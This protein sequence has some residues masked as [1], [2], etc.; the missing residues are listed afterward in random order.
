LVFV[1]RFSPKWRLRARLEVRLNQSAVTNNCQE[2]SSEGVGFSLLRTLPGLDQAAQTRFDCSRFGRQRIKKTLKLK[3]LSF[4]WAVNIY[5]TEQWQSIISLKLIT[6]DYVNM[7]GR[8]YW[9]NQPINKV[10]SAHNLLQGTRL[11]ELKFYY[12]PLFASLTLFNCLKQVSFASSIF[13]SIGLYI[14]SG[15]KYGAPIAAFSV[16]KRFGD[17]DFQSVIKTSILSRSNL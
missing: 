16:I 13:I 14:I 7:Y 1:F 12:L 4:Y 5:A 17:H 3:V 15:V 9:L 11:L 6:H 10:W 2:K 8:L